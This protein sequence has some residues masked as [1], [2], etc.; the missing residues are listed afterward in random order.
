LPKEQGRLHSPSLC[1]A[2]KTHNLP[3]PG[4]KEKALNSPHIR[5]RRNNKV[6]PTSSAR[7]A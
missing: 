1:W 3:S 6:S 4:S 5:G 2:G 7:K